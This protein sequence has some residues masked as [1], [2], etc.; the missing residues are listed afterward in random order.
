[1]RDSA[2]ITQRVQPRSMGPPFFDLGRH[3]RRG[4]RD[5]AGHQPQRP[6]GDGGDGGSVDQE[7]VEKDQ[8]EGDH[9]QVDGGDAGGLDAAEVGADGALVGAGLPLVVEAPGPGESVLGHQLPPWL[10]N[11]AVV[12]PAGG[13]PVPVAAPVEE[14]PAR[15]LDTVAP[16]PGVE[17]LVEL[18][19]PSELEEPDEVLEP[20]MRSTRP[21]RRVWAPSQMPA[22]ISSR[23]AGDPVK[24]RSAISSRASG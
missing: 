1:M 17:E 7:Q 23:P 24:G 11:G 21:P 20:R 9:H 22:R 16:T 8:P 10:W 12:R 18:L 6:L 13:W 5:D 19:E 3:G 15:V 4:G 2:T 14:T